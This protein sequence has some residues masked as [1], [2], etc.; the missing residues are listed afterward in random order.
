MLYSA[1]NDPEL[2][3]WLRWASESGEVPSFIQHSRR[4]RVLR[5]MDNYPL[6]RLVAFGMRRDDSLSGS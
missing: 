2:A 6:L 4:G 5:G 3:D 1:N